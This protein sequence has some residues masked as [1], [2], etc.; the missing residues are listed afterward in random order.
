[1]KCVKKIGCFYMRPKWRYREV[2]RDSV[3]LWTTE[4]QL[5]WCYMIR[6]LCVLLNVHRFHLFCFRST[7]L[8]A[9]YNNKNIK[10]E[11]KTSA[12]NFPFSHLSVSFT[13]FNISSWLMQKQQQQ[14]QRREQFIARSILIFYTR[15]FSV[16]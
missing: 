11:W 8:A 1:M 3:Q 13:E 7:A 2:E 12:L 15:H 10:I 5:W 9:R 14:Q 16:W 4:C 6:V